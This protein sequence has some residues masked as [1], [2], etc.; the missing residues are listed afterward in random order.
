MEVKEI[1]QCDQAGSDIEKALLHGPWVEEQVG[2][3]AE[4]K[5]LTERGR[6]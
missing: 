3:A 5:T 1:E 4:R 2:R 6:M